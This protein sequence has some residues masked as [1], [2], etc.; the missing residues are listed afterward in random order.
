MKILFGFHDT[1][2]DKICKSNPKEFGIIRRKKNILKENKNKELQIYDYPSFK[3]ERNYSNSLENLEQGINKIL[4]SPLTQML[5]E[6]DYLNIKLETLSLR[7][8]K[9]LN[10]IHSSVFL[11]K[12]IRPSCIIHHNMPHNFKSWTFCCVAE[13]MGV[14]IFYP[15]L[16]HLPWRYYLVRGLSK[17]GE[18]VE[19]NQKEVNSLSETELRNFEKIF[20]DRNSDSILSQPKYSFFNSKK[21]SNSIKYEIINFWKRPDLIVNKILCIN[22]YKNIEIDIIPGSKDVIFFLH[23]QPELST[24]PRGYNFSQQY[25]AIDILSRSLPK[26]SYLYVREHLATFKGLCSWKERN[27]NF[28]RHINSLPNVKILSLKKYSYEIM[29]NCGVVAT[30]SGTVA[31]EGFYK[32]KKVIIF[33][34]LG[35]LMNIKHNNIHIY[36]NIEKLKFFLAGKKEV[37]NSSDILL[38]IEKF[39]MSGFDTDSNNFDNLNTVNH[40]WRD[41]ARKKWIN[42]LLK[43]FEY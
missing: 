35:P 40:A 30:I 9:I 10:F 18:L 37:V 17:P 1:H 2:V 31:I 41:L 14:K 23:Y 6:R 11:L 39:S 22:Q 5:Y 24:L 16:S 27:V 20:K 7:S 21:Y 42:F 29:K 12:K 36:E 3:L 8:I 33:T 15:E 26:G 32:Q 34:P 4:W 19:I 13:L 38:N 43:K 28:Y 25:R